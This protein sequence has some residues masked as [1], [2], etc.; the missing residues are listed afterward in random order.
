MQLVFGQ[1]YPSSAEM[2]EGGETRDDLAECNAVFHTRRSGED[3]NAA[4]LPKLDPASPGQFTIC[5][6]DCVCVDV[7]APREFAR[8]WQALGNFEVVTDDT[9]DDLRHQLLA[10]GDF[11]VFGDPDAHGGFDRFSKFKGL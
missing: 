9:E 7:V 5:G 4:S 3:V 2:S 6:A 11:T 1:R 8:A 10:N